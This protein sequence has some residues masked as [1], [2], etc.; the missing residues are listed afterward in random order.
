M[1]TDEGLKIIFVYYQVGDRPTGQ[2]EVVVPYQELSDIINPEGPLQN[3]INQSQ[4]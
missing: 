2:P 3:I 1:L 4:I